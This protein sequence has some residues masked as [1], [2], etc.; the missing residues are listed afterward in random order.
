M[1]TSQV[2]RKPLCSVA[3]L[4]CGPLHL[5]VR[6][7]HLEPSPL[8]LDVVQDPWDSALLRPGQLWAC[9][10]TRSLGGQRTPAACRSIPPGGKG[11]CSPQVPAAAV[12]GLPSRGRH[13]HRLRRARPLC[14]GPQPGRRARRRP[15]GEGP[16]RVAPRWRRG[17]GR[18][19]EGR[20]GG[21]C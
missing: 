7:L 19:G 4:Q 21:C 10:G 12:E 13:H 16:E 6:P 3:A 9:R 15:L 8:V 5:P 14:V 18:L 17:G 11:S 1:K 20:G 2:S